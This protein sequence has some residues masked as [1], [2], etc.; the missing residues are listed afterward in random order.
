[1]Q[2]DIPSKLE[3]LKHQN[4]NELTPEQ[5]VRWKNISL[6][7]DLIYATTKDNRDP[8]TNKS[9]PISFIA[10][11]SDLY[12]AV[13]NEY[14]KCR[15][16][17]TIDNYVDIALY[18]LPSLKHIVS[19]PSTHIIKVPQK[20]NV[21]SLKQ[22]SPKTMQWLSKKTGRTVQEK[23]APDNKVMTNLTVFSVDTKENRETMY[24][25]R[26]LYD[27]VNKRLL[28]NTI[29]CPCLNCEKQ[30]VI[31]MREIKALVSMHTKIRKGGLAEVP[32]QKQSIQNNKLM[33]DQY[34][35][36]IWDAVRMD[37][38]Q[39]ELIR[40]SWD[41]MSSRYMQLSYWL[42]LAILLHESN[43]Y[44]HDCFGML[45][46]S[47]GDISFQVITGEH[48]EPKENEITIYAYENENENYTYRLNNNEISLIRNSDEKTIA[49]RDFTSLIEQV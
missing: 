11:L 2:I 15:G 40:Q 49:S 10:F 5:I 27:I 37:Q 19:S 17:F 30:C 4:T 14:N 16:R 44:I 43:C 45:D 34:Y 35:K 46:D 8:A 18:S 1:M 21:S 7:N 13:N 38:E 31:P 3:W 20:V 25:Y 12:K 24:L 33:C 23:I 22:T 48:I 39:E 26:I 28:D 32:A 6:L 29:P 9:N 41:K 36:K 42:V 47:N